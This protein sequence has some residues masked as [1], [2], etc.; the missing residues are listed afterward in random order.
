MILIDT[1]VLIDSFCGPRTSEFQLRRLL[2]SDEVLLS[3]IVLYEWLRGPRTADELRDQEKAL[4]SNEALAFEDAEAVIAAQI[5]R[6]VR[7][8]RSREIDIAIAATA[9]RHGADLWTLNHR[10]FDDI[11]GLRLL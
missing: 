6:S 10:D 3:V 4:P 11:P 5:Y 7:S 2:A 9:I 1:S 8:P